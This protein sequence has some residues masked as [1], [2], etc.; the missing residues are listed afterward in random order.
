[1]QHYREPDGKYEL[2]DLVEDRSVWKFASELRS[3]VE[4]VWLHLDDVLLAQAS[5]PEDQQQQLDE[6]PLDQDGGEAELEQQPLQQFLQ[7]PPPPHP[8][9]VMVKS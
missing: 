7:P 2:S 8:L 9:P 3:A 1:M 4:Y 5:D 6:A